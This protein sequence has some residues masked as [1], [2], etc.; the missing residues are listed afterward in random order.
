MQWLASPVAPALPRDAQVRHFCM[1]CDDMTRRV[2]NGSA[3][4][5]LGALAMASLSPITRVCAD[6][7]LLSPAEMKCIRASQL[8]EIL[9]CSTIESYN[10]I[11]GQAIFDCEST[12]ERCAPP[13]N[14]A[15][16]GCPAP[17]PA[18]HRCGSVCSPIACFQPGGA[19]QNNIKKITC[20]AAGSTFIVHQC[21]GPVAGNCECNHAWICPGGAMACPD[22]DVWV[23]CN[24]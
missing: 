8:G 24:N 5:A 12:Q 7:R 20:A 18:D 13:V 11:N 10:Q 9:P 21:R 14:G 23:T 4:I 19:V 17:L 6:G 1:E 2:W 15:C 3:A 22:D 16:A